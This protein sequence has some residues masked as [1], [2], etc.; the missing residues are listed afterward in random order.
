LVVAS[1][2]L[3]IEK[4][5]EDLKK[6]LK[7]T[8]KNLFDE[9]DKYFENKKALVKKSKDAADEQVYNVVVELVKYDFCKYYS[10]FNLSDDVLFRMLEKY[11]KRRIT[12]KTRKTKNNK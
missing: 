7:R 12:R 3:E 9:F 4:E 6:Q 5:R 2:I 8:T 11:I 10:K 1:E